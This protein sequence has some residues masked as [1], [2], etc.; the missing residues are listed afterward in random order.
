MTP[1]VVAVAMACSGLLAVAAVAGPYPAPGVLL[2]AGAVLF[3]CLAPRGLIVVVTTIAAVI[4]QAAWPQLGTFLG[5]TLHT[6]DAVFVAVCV[7]ALLRCS[8][9]PRTPVLK[10]LVVFLLFGVARTVLN[11][12]AESTL[13]FVRV[14]QPVVAGAVVG[15][16]LHR[17]FDLW[18]FVRWGLLA[19][20]VTVPLFGDTTGRWSGLPGGPNEVALVAAVLVVLGAA[21]SSRAARALFV[22][23]GLVGLFGSRGIGASAGALAGLAVLALGRRQWNRAAG[24]HRGVNILV[25]LVAAASAVVLIPQVRPD[26]HVT[27]WVHTVQAES[28]WG[29]FEATNPLLGS[30]WSQ[31]DPSALVDAYRSTHIEGLH[32]VY[33]DIAVYLGAVG[34]SL[35]LVILWHAWR[36]RDMATRAVLVTTLVWFNTTGAYPCAGWGILGLVVAASACQASA[37]VQPLGHRAMPGTCGSDPWE[38]TRGLPSRVIDRQVTK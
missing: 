1:L 35:F 20:L 27:L 21:D 11:N 37:S 23:S 8:S 12:G 18:R 19:V 2:L 22:L 38:P 28:F 16:V 9:A 31:V 14:M 30:G 26:L 32:N 5:G 6:G 36:P 15:L 34:A 24:T 4:H 10:F 17:D 13:S 33:L 25:V 29:A 7:A 3:V